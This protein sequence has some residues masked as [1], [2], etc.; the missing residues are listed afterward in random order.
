MRYTEIDEKLYDSTEDLLRKLEL[1]YAKYGFEHVV[2]RENIRKHILEFDSDSAKILK[3]SP[4]YFV[5]PSSLT[6]V[7]KDKIL[8]VKRE[9]F[10]VKILS[11][12]ILL[13][14]IYEIYKQYYG[15]ENVF[16]VY[17]DYKLKRALLSFLSDIKVKKG[18]KYS[19]ISIT[20]DATDVIKRIKPDYAK[21][22]CKTIIEE[23]NK[24]VF[25]S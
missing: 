16:V 17:Y 10:F 13:N 25:K 20:I 21:E 6:G 3:F 4:D 12:K 11:E 9:T 15:L 19:E 23:F 1:I 22:Q 7:S 2:P 5:M 14:E 8:K 18:S 24:S